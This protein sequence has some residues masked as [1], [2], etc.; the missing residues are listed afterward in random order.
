MT[1]RLVKKGKKRKN[2]AGD[3]ADRKQIVSE[4]KSAEKIRN[5]L[6]LIEASAYGAAN[7]G[8]P[9]NFSVLVAIGA[10]AEE[11]LAALEELVADQ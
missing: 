3:S 9:A 5:L 8:S 2:A 10:A 11:A 1:I 7:D 6:T 4:I